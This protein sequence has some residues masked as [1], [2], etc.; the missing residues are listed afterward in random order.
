M[1]FMKEKINI[2]KI[3]PLV[4]TQKRHFPANLSTNFTFCAF[5]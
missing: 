5:R 1:K 4:H 2:K 3:K